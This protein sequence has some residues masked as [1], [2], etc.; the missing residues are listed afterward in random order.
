MAVFSLANLQKAFLLMV[1]L[2]TLTVTYTLAIFITTSPM[3]KVNGNNR[4]ASLKA[5]LIMVNLFKVKYH[6]LMAV[7]LKEQ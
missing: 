1:H 2:N 3:D 4:K 6:I 5:F 7:T